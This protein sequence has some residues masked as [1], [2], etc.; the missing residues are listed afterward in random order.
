M[1]RLSTLPPK[2]GREHLLQSPKDIKEALAG[3]KS[4]VR[5]GFLG[6]NAMR[7]PDYVQT[8]NLSPDEKLQK[9]LLQ[10]L[11]AQTIE[12]NA[13]SSKSTAVM[14]KRNFVGKLSKCTLDFLLRMVPDRLKDLKELQAALEGNITEEEKSE[15][16]ELYRD[17]SP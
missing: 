17:L 1:A 16:Q 8:E 14:D 4:G 7:K 5:E 13:L 2:P 6:G 12:P 9:K 10:S 15:I 3:M 11:L